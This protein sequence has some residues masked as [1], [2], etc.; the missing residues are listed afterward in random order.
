MVRRNQNKNLRLHSVIV[1]W[2]IAVA[3][4][5]TVVKQAINFVH[6][7]IIVINQSIVV[8]N[9]VIIIKNIITADSMA[10]KV[11]EDNYSQGAFIIKVFDQDLINTAAT[12]F[13]IGV[14]S[15]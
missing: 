11:L 6:Q 15:D 4:T 7:L 14:D 13:T 10:L 12:D 1:S 3:I 9:Q 2:L 8:T 5:I